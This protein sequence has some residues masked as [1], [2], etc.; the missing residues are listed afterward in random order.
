MEIAML[1]Q[2]KYSYKELLDKMMRFCAMEE[3]SKFDVK[4]KLYNLNASKEEIEKIIDQLIDDNFLNEER[5]VRVFVKGKLSSRKWGRIK[6]NNALRQKSISSKT[7]EE[8]MEEII[9]LEDYLA[10]VRS[11]LQKKVMELESKELE[12]HKTKEKLFF[13]AASKGYEKDLIFDFMNK[14][15]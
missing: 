1:Q 13:Y 12:T 9:N 6:I 10:M 15:F 8:V 5:Y 4:T 7:I 3:K 11:V 2:K 14:Y